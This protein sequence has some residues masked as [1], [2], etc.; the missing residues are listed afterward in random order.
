MNNAIIWMLRRV[1]FV[2]TEVS[3]EC[4]SSIIRVTRIG[5]LGTTLTVTINRS[6]LSSVPLERRFLQE[7]HGVTSQY[8]AFFMSNLIFQHELRH[9]KTHKHMLRYPVKKLKAK[10]YETLTN[11]GL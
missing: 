5:E 6:T 8:T 4:I 7:P 1:A 2:V 11:V 3:E 10:I 9:L